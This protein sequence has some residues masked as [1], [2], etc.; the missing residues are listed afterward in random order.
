MN[1]DKPVLAIETSE[2]ILGACIYFSDEKYFSA[3]VLLKYSHAEKIFETVEH[4]FKTS[5]ISAHD[6]D[7]VAVSEGP[8]SF[9]GLRIG[10]SAAKGIA[11]GAG[12][13]LLPVPTYEALA[14]QLSKTFDEGKEF[15][16]SN[17]LNKDEVYYA[18]FQIKSN[19]Y[20]FV[21]DLTVLKNEEF[22]SK[23]NNFTVFGNSSLL[24]SKK[25]NYPLVPD[26]LFIAKWAV[27]FGESRKTFDYDFTEPNYLK[28]IITKE[29]QK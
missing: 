15:I 8:G 13:A 3:S 18:K 12:K 16:I 27:E 6:L 20:I 10:M 4:L 9:T 22:V 1:N 17:K 28:K 5:S 23:C 24:I 21:E 14:F 29:M 26:S 19:S 25:L 7:Y 11:Y 2:S